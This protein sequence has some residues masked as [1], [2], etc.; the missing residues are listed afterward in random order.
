M[1]GSRTTLALLAAVTFFLVG[2]GF[3]LAVIVKTVVPERASSARDSRPG[4]APALRPTARPPLGI[5]REQMRRIGF[6]DLPPVTMPPDNPLSD[7]KL[8]LGKVLF[9]DP[10]MSGNS[11]ISCATCHQPKQGWGDGVDLNFGYPNSPHWRNSQT[12]INSVYHPKLFWAGE[13][14]SLEAQANSAWTGNLAQN[15]DPDLAEE[16]LRQMPD[17]VRLF[18][19]AFGTDAP[20]FGDALRAVAAFEATI[21]SRNVPF[22]RWMNGDDQALSVAGLRGM[23]LFAGKAGCSSCHSGPV[24]TD[25]SFH[26]LGVPENPR[27]ETEPLRQVALRYQHRARGVAEDIYRSADR[28]LGLYYTTKQDA[29]KGKFRTTTLREVGQTGPYMHNGVFG[30]LQ[31]VVEFYNRGGGAD[32][33]KSP[34]MKPLGL[35]PAEIDDLLAFL[36]ALT[37]DQI[38]VEPPALPRYEVLP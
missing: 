30:T 17:Y 5:T 19:R 32:P 11:A 21:V 9:F 29:D 33:N 2:T 35:T 27:F 6:G 15:L 38:V 18:E 7:A 1:S 25:Q 20:S 36:E 10:R 37:G 24:F 8:E 26:N 13:S 31:E 28:D 12:I 16:R 34:L 4:D 3:G 14:L 22:D 23:E